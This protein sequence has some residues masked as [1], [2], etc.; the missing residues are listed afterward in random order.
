MVVVDPVGNRRKVKMTLGRLAVL[1]LIPVLLL[2]TVGVVLADDGPDAD[3][4]PVRSVELRKDDS[5]G[6]VDLVEDED[7]D[8][9]KDTGDADNTNGN[10]GT[11][12]G[13]N[14]GDG[15]DTAGDDGDRTG[16][17]TAGNDGTAGGDNTPVPV[18]PAPAVEPAPVA[19]AP[20]PAPSYD[21]GYSDDGGYSD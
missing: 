20:A 12:G 16:D 11:D 15:D 13:E 6:D 21:D 9:D 14:T 4:D 7:D 1:A 18:A 3:D 2:G 19:P 17:A 8:S 5:A 10:D